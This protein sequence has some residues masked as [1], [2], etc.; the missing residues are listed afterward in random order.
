MRIF[1]LLAS[2]DVAPTGVPRFGAYFKLAFPDVLNV[3]PG[4]IQFVDFVDGDVVVTDNHLSLLVPDHVRCVVVHHGC[5]P[6]HYS[7]DAAWRND[8]TARIAEDQR[9]MFGRP[10]R[11]YVAPSRWVADR[12]REI[13]PAGY[14]PWL[15][16]HWV[17]VI[18]QR[19]RRFGS[20]STGCKPVVIGDW[21]SPNKGSDVIAA[22]RRACPEYQFRQL[23]FAADDDAEREDFYRIADCYLCLSLSEGAPYSVA[24]AEAAGLPI[25]TTECGN[26]RE[27]STCWHG[28]A[29]RDPENAAS[30]IRAS[31]E[32]PRGPSFYRDYTF[33][34]WRS[35][36]HR[37][38]AP[39][40][41]TRD[42]E[43]SIY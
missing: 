24:D 18:E 28:N 41:A 6:Y 35:E 22:I 14:L 39:E 5:A 19:E 31:M 33:E 42:G 36:W 40:T 32:V 3:T 9:A 17:P 10:N 26:V 7:V 43:A 23:A 38:I 4:M 2:H 11:V 1:H 12:F 21:R 15:I 27:F 29:M 8:N 34:K 13:A 30:A 16:P 37:V 25:V 20:R